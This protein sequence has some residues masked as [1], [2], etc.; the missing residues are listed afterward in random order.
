M[1]WLSHISVRTKLGLLIGVFSLGIVTVAALALFGLGQAVTASRALVDTEMASLRTL[2]DMRSAV[3]NMRRYEKDMFLNLADE[4]KLLRYRDAWRQEIEKARQTLEQL[5]PSLAPAQQVG[6]TTMQ[7][8]VNRYQQAVQAIIKGIEIGQIND[9][10]AAN[11]ALE[12]HK[13]EMR[14]ADQ[15]LV[16]I[17]DALSLRSQTLVNE[18]GAMKQRLT[19]WTAGVALA[20]LAG[21]L[22][23]GYLIAIRITRP[24]EAA[25]H[26]IEKVAA[27]DLSGT[28]NV[29]GRDEIARVMQGVGEMQQSLVRIVEQIRANVHTVVRTSEIG[30]A[31]V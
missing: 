10:W 29:A 23:L 11:K 27:G 16:A 28:V 18:L 17:G 31:H 4:E 19:A 14:A 9:P 8:A 24:L 20:V 30:R 22:W 13:G 1:S 15:A 25:A 3:G 7:G 6:V 26:S 2:G 12:P 5:A 21:A